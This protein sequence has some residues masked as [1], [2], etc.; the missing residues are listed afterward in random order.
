MRASARCVCG[1]GGRGVRIPLPQLLPPL[2]WLGHSYCATVD[3]HWTVMDAAA[4]AVVSCDQP[5]LFLSY[6]RGGGLIADTE[7]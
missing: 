1:G 4:A 2:L 6:F 5:H 3:R 7:L